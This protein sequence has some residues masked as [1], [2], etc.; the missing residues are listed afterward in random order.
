MT[1]VKLLLI[2]FKSPPRNYFIREFQKSFKQYI[3]TDDD[4]R[5]ALFIP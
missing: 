2:G 1:A 3:S 4:E 5:A